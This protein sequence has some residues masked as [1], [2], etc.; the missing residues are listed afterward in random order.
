MTFQT[1]LRR[2][3]GMTHHQF[4]A[5]PATRQVEI[6]SAWLASRHR[7]DYHDLGGR[8]ILWIVCVCV[9]M[10]VAVASSGAWR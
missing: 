8:I 6:H 4:G 1:Y 10:I 3:H 9:G 5:L 7:P 2:Y